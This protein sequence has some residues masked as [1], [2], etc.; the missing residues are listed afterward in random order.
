MN[1]FHEA[2]NNDLAIQDNSNNKIT[3]NITVT[4]SK[5][6]WFR[7]NSWNCYKRNQ[8]HISVNIKT[9]ATPIYYQ[10]SPIMLYK[11]QI[12]CFDGNHSSR[13]NV[14]QKTDSGTNLIRPLYMPVELN[15]AISVRKLYFSKS[16]PLKRPGCRSESKLQ[17]VVIVSLVGMDDT[18]LHMATFTSQELNVLSITP[19][20][21]DAY[22]SSLMNRRNSICEI[23][24]RSVNPQKPY[25]Y[26]SLPFKELSI[27]QPNYTY[28]YQSF[29]KPTI[30]DELQNING[31]QQEEILAPNNL[32]FVRRQSLDIFNDVRIPTPDS[33]IVDQLVESLFM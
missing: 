25:G 15:S 21:Y 8:F 3:P 4:A 11:I 33:I 17:L 13:I 1:F 23:P 9:G 31:A 12:K 22:E 7:N 18:V 6:I 27:P 32:R 30:L 29:Q 16:T 2:R 20:Q 26:T 24:M 5:G 10:S 19:S 14:L 28:S